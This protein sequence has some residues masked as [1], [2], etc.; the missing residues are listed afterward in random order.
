MT[1]E[2]LAALGYATARALAAEPVAA[3]FVYGS[4]AIGTDR[5]GSDVDTFVL[6]SEDVGE[7]RRGIR[8]EFA[9]LQRRLGYT[10]DAEHPVELFTSADAAGA[11]D[12]AERAIRDGRL[13]RL[14]AEGDEREVLHALTDSRLLLLGGDSLDSLTARAERLAALI[15]TSSAT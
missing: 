5:V 13:D 3:V 12:D 14:T 9:R 1:R 7:R 2:T 10:P 15:R 4:V 8:A 11:L 6:L